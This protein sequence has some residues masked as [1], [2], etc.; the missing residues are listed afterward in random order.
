MNEDHAVM[1]ELLTIEVD[2]ETR[3][4][5]PQSLV[6]SAGCILTLTDLILSS[7][8]PP[9]SIGTYLQQIPACTVVYDITVLLK[10]KKKV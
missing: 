9:H 4:I 2:I 1:I 7:L 10:K 8:G 6:G 5:M 3:T